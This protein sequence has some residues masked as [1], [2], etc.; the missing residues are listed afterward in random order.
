MRTRIGTV[1]NI[2]V[3]VVVHSCTLLSR[4]GNKRAV[5]YE[6]PVSN[7]HPTLGNSQRWATP[8]TV[9]RII[10]VITFSAIYLCVIMLGGVVRLVSRTVWQLNSLFIRK[11]EER[12]GIGVGLL[13][14]DVT[15]GRP[16]CLL[17]VNDLWNEAIKRYVTRF[18]CQSWFLS[19]K[20]RTAY[21]SGVSWRSVS[22]ITHV[23][24]SVAEEL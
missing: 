24:R 15:S 7:K 23:F 2:A 20:S 22:K 10:T 3:C 16:F 1:V 5:P 21:N 17:C 6:R 14:C 18:N 19:Y 13:L 9:H 12:N 4:K 11:Q 8:L